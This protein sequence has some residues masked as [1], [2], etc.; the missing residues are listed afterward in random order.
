MYLNI[1]GNAAITSPVTCSSPTPL[2]EVDGQTSIP[3]GGWGRNAWLVSAYHEPGSSTI[4]YKGGV[5]VVASNGQKCGNGQIRQTT[6][7]LKCDPYTSNLPSIGNMT[8]T[9][10][11]GAC[12]SIREII[13]CHYEFAPIRWAGFCPSTI[14]TGAPNCSGT[15]ISKARLAALLGPGGVGPLLLEPTPSFTTCYRFATILLAGHTL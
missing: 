10:P 11:G 12:Q 15:P 14:C 1:C 8:C 5:V 7:Y 4:D 3:C 6:L 2:C 13:P 9:V